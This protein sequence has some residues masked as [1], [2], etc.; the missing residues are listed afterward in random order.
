MWPAVYQLILQDWLGEFLV[1]EQ[2]FACGIL[3][4]WLRLLTPRFVFLMMSRPDSN[5]SR[6][7]DAQALAGA[8]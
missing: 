1:R 2:G 3:A 6:A 4:A 7:A 8:F 5:A